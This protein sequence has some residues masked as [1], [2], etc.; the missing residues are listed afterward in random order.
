MFKDEAQAKSILIL[1]KKAKTQSRR[2]KRFWR[3][4]LLCEP[5]GD[6][7]DDGKIGSMDSKRK[8]MAKKQC[9]MQNPAPLLLLK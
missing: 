8:I 4:F 5:A 6:A 2:N 9:E 7:G 1:Q 3:I